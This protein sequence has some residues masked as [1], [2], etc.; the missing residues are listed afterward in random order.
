MIYFSVIQHDRMSGLQ[1][2]ID[3]CPPGREG[4]KMSFDCNDEECFLDF[5]KPEPS[6]KKASEPKNKRGKY[7]K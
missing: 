6:P 2:L 7:D 5:K 4:L 3:R 1:I